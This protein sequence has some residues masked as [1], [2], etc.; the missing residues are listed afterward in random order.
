MFKVITSIGHTMH[1]NQDEE[2]L[3][4]L[5]MISSMIKKEYVQPAGPRSLLTMSNGN[6]YNVKEP[7]YDELLK[8]VADSKRVH[9]LSF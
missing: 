6:C 5:N 7:A 3:L 9:M 2:V 8:K 1:A 4:D